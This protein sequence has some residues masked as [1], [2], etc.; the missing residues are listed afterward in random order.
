M[1]V[2]IVLYCLH[3]KNTTSVDNDR[4][5]TNSQT[6]DNPETLVSNHDNP[7][8]GDDMAPDASVKNS[9]MED[10]ER[11]RHMNDYD[12]EV[13]LSVSIDSRAHLTDVPLSSEDKQT[14]N[15]NEKLNLSNLLVQRIDEQDQVMTEIELDRIGDDSD[16]DSLLGG[17]SSQAHTRAASR[18]RYRIVKMLRN[19]RSGI[20]KGLKDLKFFMR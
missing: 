19:V 10:I 12:R 7:G 11:E 20:I 4:P 16:Q 3:S 1:C 14:N 15:S 9:E 2:L 13:T 6:D 18:I 5:S 17:D 8:S